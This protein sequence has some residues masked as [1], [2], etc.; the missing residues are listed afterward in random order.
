MDR[1]LTYLLSLFLLFALTGCWGS[2]SNNG[3]LLNPGNQKPGEENTGPFPLGDPGFTAQYKT[4]LRSTSFDRFIFAAN[5]NEIH[6]V[7]AKGIRVRSFIPEK[8]HSISGLWAD[9]G[10]AIYVTGQESDPPTKQFLRKY[11]FNGTFLGE[12]VSFAGPN[13][14]MPMNPMVGGDGFIYLYEA[15]NSKIRKFDLTGNPVSSVGGK[16][17]ISGPASYTVDRDGNIYVVDMKTESLQKFDSKG[18]FVNKFDWPRQIKG[19]AVSDMVLTDNGFI[20]AERMGSK[21][22]VTSFSHTGTLSWSRDGSEHRSPYLGN[23]MS[24]TLNKGRLFLGVQDSLIVYKVDDG[25]YITKYVK[26]MNSP[27]CVVRGPLGQFY[28]GSNNGIHMFDSAGTYVKTFGPS[29]TPI[30]GLAIDSRKNLYAIDLS[31]SNVVLRF[32]LNGTPLDPLRVKNLSSPYA[33]SIDRDDSLFIADADGGVV[34]VNTVGKS[35]TEFSSGNNFTSPAGITVAKDGSVIVMDLENGVTVGKKFSSSGQLISTF[36][37]N[38]LSTALG[39]ATSRTG[40]IFVP[41]ATNH[42][43]MVYDKDGTFL[44]SFGSKGEGLDKLNQPLGIYID[45]EDNI[46][47]ADGANHVVKKYRENGSPMMW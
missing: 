7:N 26:R 23:L 38:Q 4:F 29:N 1:A 34:K 33:M 2:S 21:G 44:T 14:A 9:N 45:P 27:K 30:M 28:V 11:D 3:N 31:E 18:N 24:L 39:V 13:W 10:G 37:K 5:G 8:V 19:S 17:V 32:D 40:K 22:R 46:F 6:I 25:S 41:D 43:V 42:K 16:E 47:V 12:L 35:A 15:A 36:G 20:V